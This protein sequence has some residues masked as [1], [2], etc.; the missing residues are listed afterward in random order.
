MSPRLQQDLKHC[1]WQGFCSWTEERWIECVNYNVAEKLARHLG[2]ESSGQWLQ[3]HLT[4]GGECHP[5]GT[6]MALFILMFCSYSS[7]SQISLSMTR[8]VI[9]RNFRKFNKG[10]CQILCPAWTNPC[11][12]TGWGQLGQTQI[13]RNR[14]SWKMS[15]WMWVSSATLQQW[16][17]PAYWTTLERT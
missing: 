4:S 11:I 6:D 2:K 16:R 3:A 12:S 13:C 17:L 7:C 1:F 9:Q 10:K 15:V 5:S 14:R 8:T